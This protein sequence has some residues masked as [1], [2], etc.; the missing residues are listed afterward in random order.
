[1]GHGLSNMLF[2][3]SHGAEAANLP[4]PQEQS[5]Q[6]REFGGQCSIQAKGGSEHLMIRSGP[7]TS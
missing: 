7:K 1:M 4:P 5:Y 3:S 2:G 6:Q